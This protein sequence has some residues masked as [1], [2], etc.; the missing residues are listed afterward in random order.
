ML[1]I[2]ASIANVASQSVFNLFEKVGY[3]QANINFIEDG[4]DEQEFRKLTDG[5]NNYVLPL[6]NLNDLQQFSR[7]QL[8]NSRVMIFYFEPQMMLAKLLAEP[9]DVENIQ[10]KLQGWYDL[11]SSALEFYKKNRAGCNILNFNECLA[12][13]RAFINLISP[14]SSVTNAQLSGIEPVKPSEVSLWVAQQLVLKMVEINRLYAELE[15][16]SIEL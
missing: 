12:N 14:E 9:H 11:T 13:P 8:A 10:L 5:E 6:E 1:I 4:I 3:S 2:T 15:A 16:C 7:K